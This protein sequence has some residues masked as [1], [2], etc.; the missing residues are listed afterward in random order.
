MVN[1]DH[2]SELQDELQIYEEENVQD[3]TENEDQEEEVEVYQ[4]PGP[5]PLPP[6]WVANVASSGRV[7]F[8][9]FGNR[10]TTWTD[11]RTGEPTGF[12]ENLISPEEAQ[13]VDALDA[14]SIYERPLPPG[15][16]SRVAPTGRAFFVNFRNNK[17][18][19]KDPRTGQ[20][21][22]IAVGTDA[23]NQKISLSLD[24]LGPLPTGWEERLSEDGRI[25]FINHTKKKTTWEDPRFSNPQLAGRK[26]EYS[27]D[28]KYKYEHFMKEIRR[29]RTDH[30]NDGVKLRV[31]RSE[32]F[33]D[34]YSILKELGRKEVKRLRNRLWIE[35]EGEVGYDYGGV[36]RE[37]FEI[38]SV[39]MFNPYYGLFE[40]SAVDNYTL[41]INPNSGLCNQDHLAVFKFIGRVAG[42]AIM[43]KRLLNGFF[44]CP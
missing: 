24:S 38:L 14:L 36:S 15:W 29:G 3:L 21:T 25:F 26:I 22:P 43:H 9:N 12:P 40:Y 35:F 2:A 11:P 18:T 39:E 28:Y 42:M 41:Q 32:V 33:S 27:R 5:L 23:E 16:V 30:I 8:T 13:A 6:G 44:I 4:E 10:Q 31:R 37:W 20:L 7:Y 17:T 1:D 19:F 34:S